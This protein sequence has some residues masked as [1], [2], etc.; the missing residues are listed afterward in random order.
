MYCLATLKRTMTDNIGAPGTNF[1]RRDLLRATGSAGLVGLAGCS[2]WGS[3][4]ESPAETAT[5]DG[6]DNSEDLP[7]A[8]PPQI[9]DV[10]EQ[11]NQVTLRSVTSSLPV[12]PGDAMGGPVELPRVWAWQADDRQPS[13]PGPIIRT[14]EGEDMEVTLDN[15]DAM[16][17]NTYSSLFSFFEPS[18]A[19][20]ERSRTTSSQPSPKATAA[21][22]ARST[23]TLVGE[24]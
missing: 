14:Q 22:P 9:V 16:N 6:S 1:S 11:N 3:S 7:S 13:V 18:F 12:H 23:N 5:Q 15:T 19:A 21:N 20:D 4:A 10:T 8:G 2:F 17:G 24:P